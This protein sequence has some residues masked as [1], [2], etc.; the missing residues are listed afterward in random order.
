[1]SLYSFRTGES[2][3]DT[4]NGSVDE[5]SYSLIINSDGKS[6]CSFLRAVGLGNGIKFVV[7][8]VCS[9]ERLE[10]FRKCFERYIVEFY[11]AHMKPYAFKLEI[12][13]SEVNG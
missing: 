7:P 6:N 13:T 3:T 2:F 11:R 9:E 4:D 10:K 1:L 5:P 12:S 8:M